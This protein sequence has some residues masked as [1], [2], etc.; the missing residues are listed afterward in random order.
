MYVWPI[1]CDRDGCHDVVAMD[2]LYT[3]DSLF[4]T[5]NPASHDEEVPAH[6]FAWDGLIYME[7]EQRSSSLV[8]PFDLQDVHTH[9]DQSLL[10]RRETKHC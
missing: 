10:L 8:S 9:R 5:E 1:V 2:K 7:A 6:R 3:P 4:S